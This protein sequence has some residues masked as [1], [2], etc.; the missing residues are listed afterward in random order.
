VLRRGLVHLKRA[1]WPLA[2]DSSVGGR[3][4][5]HGGFLAAAKAAVDRDT[6]D[7]L[8]A[9]TV[10]ANHRLE[11]GIW[12]SPGAGDIR[13][14]LAACERLVLL[15]S[16]AEAAGGGPPA[17]HERRDLAVLLLHGG[18]FGAAR[19]EMRAY[20]A[21]P[22]ASPAAAEAAREDPLHGALARRV[23]DLLESLGRLGDE[24]AEVTGLAAALRAP[25]PAADPERR[26]PLTW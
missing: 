19:A 3:R 4:G 10:V 18:R 8:R 7:A 14:S 12:T 1:Y 21:S 16:A 25:P 26:K 11:R 6:S 13:R 5:S 9:I 15:D 17:G 22:A 24:P 20:L 2:W 23:M